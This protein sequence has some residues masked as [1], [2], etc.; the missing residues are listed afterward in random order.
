MLLGPVGNIE[1]VAR[2]TEWRFSETHQFMGYPVPRP[3]APFGSANSWGSAMGLLTPYFLKS[4]VIGVAPQRRRLG[5]LLGLVGIY[6]ILISVNRGL[7][8]SLAVGGAYYAARKAL[9]GRFSALAVLMV[10]VVVVAIAL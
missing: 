2:I 9:R 5:I 3:A 7:W 10:G 1:F 8:L 4:W 6:P